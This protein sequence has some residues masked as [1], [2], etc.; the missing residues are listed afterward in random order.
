MDERVYEVQVCAACF[1]Q[2]PVIVGD[3]DFTPDPE[4]PECGS[5]EST[6][7]RFRCARDRVL[8]QADPHRSLVERTVY[9]GCVGECGHYYWRRGEGGRPYKFRNPGRS[10][11]DEMAAASPWGSSIDGGLFPRNQ[12]PSKQ[13]EAH[14]F[15]RDGWTAL[16]FLDRSVDTRPGSW[17]VY[18]IPAILDGPEALAVAREAF[19]PIFARY[20]FPVQVATG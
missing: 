17:S 11:H 2:V 3:P 9:F 7:I 20:T 18:C 4:C 19:P 8:A 6:A 12:G 16:A 15:H 1:T 5:K 13:G 10:L 14:T